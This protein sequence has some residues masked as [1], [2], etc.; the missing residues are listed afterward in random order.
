MKS[1]KKEKDKR[2]YGY[3]EN[4]PID[5]RTRTRTVSPQNQHLE[6][7]KHA[8]KLR[9]V[10]TAASKRP[11]EHFA[12]LLL[13]FFVRSNSSPLST[14]V[15]PILL[16]SVYYPIIYYHIFLSRVRQLITQVP[17]GCSG[18]VRNGV[19]ENK[20]CLRK[21]GSRSLSGRT[22]DSAKRRKKRKKDKT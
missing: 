22:S 9:P 1:K 13:R 16:F 20:G 3:R 8:T 12:N 2:R 10:S 17:S 19:E 18:Q 5:A 15:N 7:S 11:T 4:S 6:H 21:T 14:M